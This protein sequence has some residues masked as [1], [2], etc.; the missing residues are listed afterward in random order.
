MFTDVIGQMSLHVVKKSVITTVLPLSEP[1]VKIFPSAPVSGIA[2]IFA[3]IGTSRMVP[4]AFAA[5]P[6]R[7]GGVD[8]MEFVEFAIAGDATTVNRSIEPRII[9]LVIAGLPCL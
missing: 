5:K 7:G 9:L 2:K 3:G 6:A 4:P 1:S 8:I